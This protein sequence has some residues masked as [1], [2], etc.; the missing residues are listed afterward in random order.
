MIDKCYSRHY[1]KAIKRR[2]V[3]ICLQNR[4][5]EHKENTQAE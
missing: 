4:S 2:D 1:N 5:E 3:H